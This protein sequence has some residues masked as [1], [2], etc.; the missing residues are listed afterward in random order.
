MHPKHEI[1]TIFSIHL[2]QMAP[3]SVFTVSAFLFWTLTS[4]GMLFDNSSYAWP[5]E[6]LRS[7]VFLLMYVKFGAWNEFKIPS[8]I[9]TATFSISLIIALI[10]ISARV[11]NDIKD[12]KELPRDESTLRIKMIMYNS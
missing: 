6:L 9:L 2:Q 8:P 5:N 10:S 12:K 7:T 4:I 11:R 1:C 3:L